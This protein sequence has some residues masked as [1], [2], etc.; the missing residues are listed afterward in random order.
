MTREEHASKNPRG[1]ERGERGPRRDDDRGRRDERPVRAIPEQEPRAEVSEG[2]QRHLVL[3]GDSVG[4]RRSV[5]GPGT[6]MVG[7]KLV[8]TSAGLMQVTGEKVSVVPMNGCYE[9]RA[10]DLVVA[11]VTEANP[12]NWIL[13]IKAPWLAP[14]HVSEVPWRVDFGETTSYLKPGDA[15]LCKIL[16]VDEQRKVQVTLKD[17][18]LSKLEGGELIEV[19]PVKV[20][21]VIGKNG[22]MVNLLKEYIECW[23]FVGQNGRIWINGTAPEVLLAKEAIRMIADHAHL[24]EMTERVRAFLEQRRPGGIDAG[25]PVERPER[26]R[27]E[28]TAVE[29]PQTEPAETGNPR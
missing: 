18:N 17:R 1:R 9:P 25:L 3:P 29:R 8:A 11:I 19:P 7:A 22:S 21:R 15:V 12:G 13:D 23:M 24:P 4:D 10:G 6:K 27:N 20:A 26:R 16:F 28:E 2:S 5:A 14:M